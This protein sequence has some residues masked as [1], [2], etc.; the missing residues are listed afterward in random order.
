MAREKKKYSNEFIEYQE[1]IVGHENYEGIP[2]KRKPDGSIV[3]LAPK[4]TEIG[5]GRI[6]WARE[7]ADEFG[8]NTNEDG[9]MAK[10]MYEVHPTKTKPCQTCG[11]V[12]N[13][14]YIYA[15][16]SF[17]KSIYKEFDCIDDDYQIT[18]ITDINQIVSILLDC[19]YELEYIKEFLIEKF[20]LSKLNKNSDINVIIDEC[21]KKC[22]YGTCKNLGPGAMS[23]FPDRLCGFHSYN[24]CCRSK[25]DK[26]RHKENMDSYNKDRR[27]YE[28]WSDGNISLANKYMKSHYFKGATADHI[29]PISLGFKHE[30]VFMQR[31]T[32]S[33]NSSKRD[34]LS[35][36]DIKKL[37]KLERKYSKNSMS[38]YG[39]ILWE[40]IKNNYQNLDMEDVRNALKQ[41]VHNY[42]EIL[43]VIKNNTGVD[44]LYNALIK[45]K[46]EYFNYDYKFDEN[47]YPTNI[48]DKVKTDLYNKEIA[49]LYRVSLD[50]IDEYH[51]KEN[52]NLKFDLSYEQLEMLKSTIAMI[53]TG[54]YQKSLNRLRELMYSIQNR[55]IE[56]YLK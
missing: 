42:M 12:L 14:N 18:E 27:A 53:R 55:L 44:F 13:L 52:R 37:I 54:N 41:N 31:A 5:R 11:K 26:G 21:I 10:V 43:Y 2:Y 4:Q 6:E 23:N 39:E 35:E 24:R 30:S 9:W 48:Q 20:K 46:E 33:E 22:K 16:K 56:C 8:I 40:F 17:I 19:E 3:W 15:S 28:Y 29:G 47:G 38:W 25:E 36:I 51:N 7:K 34:R 32:A 1:Y 50:S 49:R 45:H